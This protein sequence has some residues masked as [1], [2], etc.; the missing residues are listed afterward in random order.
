LIWDGA[1]YHKSDEVKEFLG[2]VNDQNKP[3]NRAIHGILF[4]PNSPEQNPVEDVWLQ[5]KNF[6]RK[7]WHLC[8]SFKVVK[9]LFKFFTNHQK[10]D[11]LKLQ[12]YVPCL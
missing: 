8:K 6:V 1:S 2:A 7:Y 9:W 5:A 4:A 10:F 12:Q 11:F 3:E